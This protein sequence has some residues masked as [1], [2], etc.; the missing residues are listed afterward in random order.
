MT[1]VTPNLVI[2]EGPNRVGKTTLLKAVMSQS[3]VGR[4]LCLKGTTPSPYT[5]RA[6]LEQAWKTLQNIDNHVAL[7]TSGKI[8]APADG[9]VQIALDRFPLFSDRVYRPIYEGRRSEDIEKHIEA[10]YSALKELNTSVVVFDA[11]DDVIAERFRVMEPHSHVGKGDKLKEVNAAYRELCGEISNRYG[12]HDLH[13][14]MR[15]YNDGT[16]SPEL[17]ARSIIAE[18]KVVGALK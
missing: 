1:T 6:A 13:Y 7:I 15:I 3:E 11:P 8:E 17:I 2:F 5:P 10:L 16:V 4:D 18:F 12:Q 9:V 14:Y